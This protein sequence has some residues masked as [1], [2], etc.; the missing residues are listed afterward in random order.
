MCRNVIAKTLYL[1]SIEQFVAP[2]VTAVRCLNAPFRIMR[3]PGYHSH[4][5]PSIA[6]RMRHVDVIDRDSRDLGRVI[7]A[8]KYDR[9]QVLD[10]RIHFAFLRDNQHGK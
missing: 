6:K 1:N 3:H 10:R 9:R 2:Q 7:D 5:V 8:D 4:H